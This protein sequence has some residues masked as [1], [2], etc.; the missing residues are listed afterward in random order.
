[1]IKIKKPLRMMF[2]FS[3]PLILLPM[4]VFDYRRVSGEMPMYLLLKQFHHA[5]RPALEATR[6]AGA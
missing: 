1:M 6:V 5:C 3:C 4:V 2:P